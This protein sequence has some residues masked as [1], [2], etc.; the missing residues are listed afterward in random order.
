M[1]SLFFYVSVC[2]RPRRHIKHRSLNSPFGGFWGLAAVSQL[3]LGGTKGTRGTYGGRGLGGV[4]FPTPPSG[5]L[6]G[7][8]KPS[9]RDGSPYVFDYGGE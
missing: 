3:P 8:K 7:F 9:K 4:R 1:G 2:L 5:D 6:G